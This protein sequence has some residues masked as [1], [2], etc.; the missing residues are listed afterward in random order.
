LEARDNPVERGTASFINAGLEQ[1]EPAGHH[2]K[3]V[4]LPLSEI[5]TKRLN[6]TYLF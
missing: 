6:Y 3:V 2:P 4:I 5:L 1:A